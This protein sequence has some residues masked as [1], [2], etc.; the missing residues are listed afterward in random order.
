MT[1]TTNNQTDTSKS[2][3]DI[4]REAMLVATV[5]SDPDEVTVELVLPAWWAAE[6]ERC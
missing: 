3:A 6:L 5:F 2:L 4:Q 1:T